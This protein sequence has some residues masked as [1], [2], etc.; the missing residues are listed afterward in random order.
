M[1][2]IKNARVT[3]EGDAGSIEILKNINLEFLPNK[4]YAITGPNGGGKSTLAK[5]IMGIIPSDDGTLY[6]DGKD[7]SKNTIDERGR[8]GIGYA[9]QTPPRFKGLSVKKILQLSCGNKNKA[10]EELLKSVGLC[11]QDYLDRK[12]DATFSG[13][14]LKRIEIA[15]ILA[16]NLKVAVFDEPE[17]G[18][19]LWSF[20]KLEETFIDLH[21]NTDTTIVIISHQER[22]L[23]LA[24]E[25]IVIENGSV[26]KKT[27]QEKF[28]SE[29]NGNA[30]DCICKH[31]CSKGGMV[32]VRH[33]RAKVTV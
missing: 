1:L 18:I 14:E 24:D 12:I 21:K 10:L 28:L 4:I 15:S 33:N 2:E 13:G 7:I 26:L 32:N 17:A 3:V 5:Y 19:D 8:M 29:I 9:F 30:N 31:N 25:I 16:R 22:I 6:L 27:T 20:Q 11:P 23:S